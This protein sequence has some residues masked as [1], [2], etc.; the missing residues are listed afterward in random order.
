MQCYTHDRRDAQTRQ[1]YKGLNPRGNLLRQRADIAMNS[2]LFTHCKP[3]V[4]RHSFVMIDSDPKGKSYL[5]FCCFKIFITMA[6][7]WYLFPR[8]TDTLCCYYFVL[9]VLWL[10]SLNCIPT[11]TVR[12]KNFLR[13]SWNNP[14][15]R[16]CAGSKPIAHRTL[17][18]SLARRDTC[19]GAHDRTGVRT[20]CSMV[21]LRGP[22]W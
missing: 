1:A 16:L 11:G 22:S 4:R 3:C 14:S 2:N 10:F 8:T 9:L 17:G 20:L 15:R 19:I 13:R 18:Q 5:L 6:L 12:I 7:Q 21:I